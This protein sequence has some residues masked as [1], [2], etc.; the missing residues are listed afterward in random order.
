MGTEGSPLLSWFPKEL[1]I[2]HSPSLAES[3]E[4]VPLCTQGMTT[5]LLKGP[6]P[7]VL[8]LETPQRILIGLCSGVSPPPQNSC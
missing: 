2:D 4:I 8:F 7:P 1:S 3:L 5:I 6:L